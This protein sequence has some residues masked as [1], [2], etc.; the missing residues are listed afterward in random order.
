[1]G[2]ATWNTRTVLAAAGASAIT[3]GALF[4][5]AEVITR[6]F[7][8]APT[9]ETDPKDHAMDE[10]GKPCQACGNP[11]SPTDP[12]ARFEGYLIHA[13]HLTDPSSGLYGGT[14]DQPGRSPR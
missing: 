2:I 12:P 1:M 3:L 5:A 6:P 11:T 9:P 4:S 14:P 8:P 7:V 13:R 10:T